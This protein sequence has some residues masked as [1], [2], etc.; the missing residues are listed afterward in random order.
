MTTYWLSDFCSLFNSLNINPFIGDDKN[1]QFNSL[2]R[3]IIFIT[4]LCAIL[5]QD[6]SNQIFLGGAIS[7]F[8]SVVIY[9]L[10]Y[11]SSEM[12][13][14][15]TGELKSYIDSQKLIKDQK[16]DLKVGL[17][18]MGEVVLE[19]QK[20]NVENE[21]TLDYVPP[22]TK[23]IKTA[24]FLEGNKMPSHVTNEPRD[25]KDYISLGKQVTPGT[26]KQLHSLIGKNLSVPM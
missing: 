22:N 24:M 4:F 21:V 19:D 10:T 8:L 23:N 17:S 5:F 7:I 26:A 11:N 1:F 18:K 6:S 16:E 25:P 20:I 13:T 3:L 12:S 14:R 15:F 9:M 2:T